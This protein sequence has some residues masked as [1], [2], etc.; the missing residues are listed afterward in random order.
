MSTITD[1]LIGLGIDAGEYAGGLDDASAKSTSFIDKVTGPLT[2]AMVGAFAAGGVAVAGFAAVSVS[3]FADFQTSMNEVFTLLPGISEDAMSDMTDQVKQF[4]KDFGVLPEDVVPALYQSLSAGVPKDNVFQFLEDAN[5]AAVAG[6]VDL[7]VAVNG[8]SSVVNAYGADVVDSAK[9]SDLLFTTVKLG[10]TT[11]GELSDAI[12]NV[13][14]SAA[15]AGVKFEEVTAALAAMTLQGVPTSVATT[16]LRATIDE[17]SKAGTKT[18]TIFRE[19]AGKSFKEFIAG[20]GD[21]Q[22]ALQLLEQHAKDA[23]LGIN[24]L[25]GSAEAGSTALLLT[26]KGTDAFTAS[27]EGMANSAGATDTAFA[28]M[29]SGITDAVDDI[30]AVFA[31][32]ML[33]VGERLAPFAQ[34]FADTLGTVLPPLLEM[35]LALVD[36]A[37]A[38]VNSIMTAEDPIFAVTNALYAFS[39]LLGDLVGYF[40]V[41]TTEG[42]RFNDF[43]ANLPAPIQTAI[44]VIN[45]IIDLIGGNLQPILLAV[46]TVIGVVVVAAIG[47]FIASMIAV[48]APIIAVIAVIALLYAA[49]QN[50][51]LGIRDVVTSVMNAVWSVISVIIDQVMAFWKANGEDILAFVTSNFQT[52]KETIA[53]ALE[54]IK[55]V[56]TTIFTAVAGFI[57]THGAEIQ[58]YLN[59]TWT[60]IKNVIGAAVTLISGIIKA[61]LQ[62]LKGDWSGAWQTIVTMSRT[63]VQQI[64][65]AIKAAF[66]NILILTKFVWDLIYRAIQSALNSVVSWIS[67]TFQSIVGA[68]RGFVSKATDAA[69]SVGEGIVSGITKAIEAGVASIVNAAKNA[70]MDALNAAKAA[71]GIGSPSKLA[72]REIGEPFMEGIVIG[73]DRMLSA[74]GA[75]GSSAGLALAAGASAT[76]PAITGTASSGVAVG[77]TGEAA[78]GINQ[79]FNI[80]AHY[81]RYQDERTLRDTIRMEAALNAPALG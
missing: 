24:D 81:A 12:F 80:E 27:L 51:F 14:P 30:K 45:S 34:L 35:F 65:T 13:T 47:S 2:T 63:F 9:A 40:L 32:F 42:D 66:D 10:K 44:G 16:K 11:F 31:V 15:A 3:K 77:A 68:I 22:G 7:D 17:L 46:A 75:A 73:V 20:G 78:G 60:V 33:E 41:A 21:L 52:I 69:S 28:T 4:S 39:P 79:N 58:A 49:F 76:V 8:V 64:W 36:P 25:F 6:V 54:I 29:N 70:A 56:V 57:K 18:D 48:A 53:N 26:G 1:L 38:F 71:L 19:V 55:I 23:N 5:K 43:F 62:I 72:I 61:F 50:N 37:L 59:N 74:V 67:L